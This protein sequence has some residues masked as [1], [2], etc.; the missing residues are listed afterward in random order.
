MTPHLLQHNTS[1]PS[2]F[3]A[4]N[5]FI[6][7]FPD[8]ILEIHKNFLNNISYKDAKYCVEILKNEIIDLVN[9]DFNQNRQAMNESFKNINKFNYIN[10]QTIY[11]DN[12][13]NLELNKRNE[14]KQILKIS[15]DIECESFINNLK[16]ID[17]L[18]NLIGKLFSK[19]PFLIK[20]NISELKEFN[21]NFS[22]ENFVRFFESFFNSNFNCILNS[23]QKLIVDTSCLPQLKIIE[24]NQ[25]DKEIISELRNSRLHKIFKENN[26]FV[27]K[28]LNIAWVLYLEKI[29]KNNFEK[30][31][32]FFNHMRNNIFNYVEIDL[33]STIFHNLHIDTHS[34]ILNSYFSINRENILLKNLLKFI[35][36]TTIYAENEPFDQTLK[37]PIIQILNILIDHYKKI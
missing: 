8:K 16:K 26:N 33:V 21:N 3:I 29:F 15:N 1:I 6:F 20:D 23:N 9:Y 17:I 25:I 24:K 7:K 34:L 18:W 31:E 12:F 11:F 10:K 19:T 22:I 36:T 5:E 14:L 27:E 32:S 30:T 35:S 2:S 28:H 4:L 13:K 37:I